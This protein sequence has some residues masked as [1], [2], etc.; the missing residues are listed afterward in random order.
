[1]ATENPEE[2]PDEETP[3]L[4]EK[5]CAGYPQ[6][7]PPKMLPVAEFS[8]TNYD[9]GVPRYRAKCRACQ[10]WAQANNRSRG[11]PRKQRNNF[12]PKKSNDFIDDPE[13]LAMPM[14]D[15]FYEEFMQH[16]GGA[17]GMAQIASEVVQS[18]KQMPSASAALL[19][20]LV[21]TTEKRIAANDKLEEEREWCDPDDL[22]N[23]IDDMLTRLDVGSARKLY[24]KIMYVFDRYK[25]AN[26]NHATRAVP[27]L[28]IDMERDFKLVGKRFFRGD[29]TEN[30]E[31]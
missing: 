20:F 1:M 2:K 18:K 9:S 21:Q 10:Q 28:L 29:E 8:I 17:K 31:S 12:A 24:D 13:L 5:L 4:T 6:T 26:I 16:V 7:H 22:A 23:E 27:K 3:V 11:R 25:V 19:K 14:V 30:T 15:D